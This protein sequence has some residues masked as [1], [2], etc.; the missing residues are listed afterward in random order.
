LVAHLHTVMQSPTDWVLQPGSM[1]KLATAYRATVCWLPN[2]AF[3]FMARRMPPA[4]RPALD[5]SSLRAMVNCSEP[6]RLQSMQ[7]FRDAFGP[8]GL[9]PAALQTSY[10]MAEA[11]FAVTQSPID[12]ASRPVAI[13]VDR[14]VFHADGR[15][16]LV[17]PEDPRALA[18]VSSGRCLTGTAVRVVD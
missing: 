16:D 11:T 15:A 9:A 13:W 4:D 2:F 14:D 8:V 7:E 18:F 12:G 3:Q 10:A 6:V 17:A 1:L 5:L